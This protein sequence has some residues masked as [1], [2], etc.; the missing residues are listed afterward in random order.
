MADI[1]MKPVQSSNINAV[2]YDEL[3]QVMHVEFT[4][5]NK[6]I[7]F[8]VPPKYHEAFIGSDSIGKHFVKH[9]RGH[10]DFQKG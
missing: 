5:G 7:Y 3:N 4:N 8:D 9:V 10:F 6:Y 2:G 1:E